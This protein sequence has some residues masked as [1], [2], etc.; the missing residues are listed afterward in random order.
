MN[1]ADFKHAKIQV[2]NEDSLAAIR[3]KVSKHF[4]IDHFKLLFHGRLISDVSQNLGFYKMNANSTIHVIESAPN[5]NEEEAS[6]TENAKKPLPS[7]E[8]IQRFLT[9]FGLAVEEPSFHKIALKLGR[10]EN[11]ENIVA[12]CPELAKVRLCLKAFNTQHVFL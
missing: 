12:T 7:D 8:E 1:G 10:K 9:N 6:E 3:E 2:E 4:N 11:L 5:V